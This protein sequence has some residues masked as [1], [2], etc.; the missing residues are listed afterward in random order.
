LPGWIIGVLPS[1]LK[2]W[3]RGPAFF[4]TN[5]TL[6][7]FHSVFVESVEGNSTAFTSIVVV[8]VRRRR[9]VLRGDPP[10]PVSPPPACR[11]QTRCRHAT[12]ICRTV[13]RR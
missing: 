5:V 11:F 9:I 8:L 13:E 4:T 3:E 12:E 1:I 7:G 6:P 2:S 10:S